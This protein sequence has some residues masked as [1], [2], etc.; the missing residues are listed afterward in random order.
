MYVKETR[1]VREMCFLECSNSYCILCTMKLLHRNKVYRCEFCI[2]EFSR[3]VYFKN[4][5]ATL[6]VLNS[7]NVPENLET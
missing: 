2:K 6:F 4:L 1:I 3:L 5:T 7:K